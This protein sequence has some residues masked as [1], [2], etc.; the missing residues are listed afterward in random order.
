M[1]NLGS[2]RGFSLRLEYQT[3]NFGILPLA[4]NSLTYGGI[5]MNTKLISLLLLGI[6]LLLGGCGGLGVQPDGYVVDQT[7]RA[8]PY[9]IPPGR[10]T[11][12][13]LSWLER[14]EYQ[15]CGPNAVRADTIAGVAVGAT[16]GAVLAGRC[17]R[18]T[19]AVLGGVGG[20][21]LSS[22]T[23]GQYC[24]MLRTT[25]DLVTQQ[26]EDNRAKSACV[27]RQGER[28]G[29]QYSSTDCVSTT[30]PRPGYNNFPR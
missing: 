6:S 15:R 24:S 11:G 22:M 26:I 19:G 13:Q 18:A 25:R 14:E 8:H 29:K 1:R 7:G 16:L 9:I 4:I 17:A 10:T 23:V 21:A 28:D 5:T 27:H 2:F 30:G 3:G 12:E 20:G